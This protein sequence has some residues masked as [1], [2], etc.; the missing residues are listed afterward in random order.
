MHRCLQTCSSLL[1][2]LSHACLLIPGCQDA[3]TSI[4]YI[5]IANNEYRKTCPLTNTRS[6]KHGI[7]ASHFTFSAERISHV[8]WEKSFINKVKKSP[9]CCLL[10]R[11][12]FSV[13]AGT[14]IWSLRI[15]EEAKCAMTWKS[16]L[17]SGQR[18]AGSFYLLKLSLY[19]FCS[20]ERS[21]S[22]KVYSGLMSKYD[23]YDK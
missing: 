6:D 7:D 8:I 15:P 19:W 13:S 20:L 22:I 16:A 5:T 11:L 3:N 2:A 21:C 23:I 14:T 10:S 1:R 18:W 9:H 12:Y 4:R 17:R